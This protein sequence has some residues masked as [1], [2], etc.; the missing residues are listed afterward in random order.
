[1]INS[2]SSF[3]HTIH[4]VDPNDPREPSIGVN[5]V[6]D[7]VLQ[8]VE[9]AD[10]T[11]VDSAVDQKLAQSRNNKMIVPDDE[12]NDKYDRSSLSRPSNIAIQDL[13]R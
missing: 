4:T 12:S 2:N 7:S 1:M 9:P 11:L 6:F 13:L 5:H 8:I 3:R 10:D